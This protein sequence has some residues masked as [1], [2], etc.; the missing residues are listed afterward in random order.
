MQNLSAPPVSSCLI[1]KSSSYHLLLVLASWHRT[2]NVSDDGVSPPQKTTKISWHRMTSAVD[3]GVVC[4]GRMKT[5]ITPSDDACCCCCYD[6]GDLSDHD[7]TVWPH[8]SE[9]VHVPGRWITCVSCDL[10]PVS[11]RWTTD[12]NYCVNDVYGPQ[13]SVGRHDDLRTTLTGP[14]TCVTCDDEKTMNV[15]RPTPMND[16]LLKAEQQ[17]T[18]SLTHSS[19]L[20]SYPTVSDITSTPTLP[21]FHQKLD[22]YP[23][24]TTLTLSHCWCFHSA[25]VVLLV[26]LGHLFVDVM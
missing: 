18:A 8:C 10:D 20:I 15:W 19:S 1:L 11:G 23:S 22:T 9:R 13:T 5:S 6:A 7:P 17:Q 21:A 26:L 12:V 14:G 3:C 24:I 25:T 2:T 4:W 16:E